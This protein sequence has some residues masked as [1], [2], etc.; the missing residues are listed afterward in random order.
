M[1][2]DQL[3]GQWM[4]FKGELKHTWGDFTDNDLEDING[5]Y[6]KFVRKVQ[7][8][9]S[10]STREVMNWAEAWHKKPAFVEAK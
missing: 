8:R 2:A 4:Q 10:D 5:S 1:D 9:Y 6:D 7:E 3:K